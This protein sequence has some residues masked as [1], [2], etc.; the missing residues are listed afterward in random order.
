M[1]DRTSWGVH[2][3][4]EQEQCQS[5][6]NEPFEESLRVSDKKW[7]AYIASIT[8]TH[9][10]RRSGPPYVECAHI[11]LKNKVSKDFDYTSSSTSCLRVP[12]NSVFKIFTAIPVVVSMH[13]MFLAD[14]RL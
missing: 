4:A 1:Q 7:S 14:G 11:L 10:E 2:A 8:A 13:M 9:Q 12:S 5:W 6:R 3:T